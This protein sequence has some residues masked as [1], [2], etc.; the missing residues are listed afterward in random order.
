M[1]P[2]ETEIAEQRAQSMSETQQ[3]ERQD[4]THPVMKALDVAISKADSTAARRIEKLRAK[5]PNIDKRELVAQLERD[6]RQSLTVTGIASGAT[7]AVP[8]VSTLAGLAAVTGD[9]AWYFTRAT[10]YIISLANLYDLDFDDIERQRALVM[11]ALLG[12]SATG[13][14]TRAAATS[15][16]H[17]GTQAVAQ[18]PMHTVR[19][20]NKKLGPYFITKFSQRGVIQLGKMF[21]FGIGAVIGGAGN[22]AIAHATILSVRKVFKEFE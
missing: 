9:I 2:K 6:F 1:G 11:I 17:L 21:P 20:I 3:N 7:S 10:R 12:E 18:I 15:G 13:I 16:K 5:N 14:A 8:G 22:Y 4:R 19:A